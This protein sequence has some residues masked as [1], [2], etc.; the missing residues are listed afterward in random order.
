MRFPRDSG[1]ADGPSL[2]LRCHR[3]RRP[4]K[5]LFKLRAKIRDEKKSN[6][7]GRL[8]GTAMRAREHCMPI[9]GAS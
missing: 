5:S 6:I 4:A 3:L 7:F 1:V 9:K 2:D 8:S